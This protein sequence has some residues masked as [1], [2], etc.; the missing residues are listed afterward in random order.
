MI[1]ERIVADNLEALEAKKRSAP[2]ADIQRMALAQPAPLDFAAALRGEAI[3]L[4]AEVKKA[5]PSKGVIRPDFNAVE[6]ART[7]AG[8]GAAAISVLT[9]ARYFQ[10][11]LNYLKVVR[12]RCC[13]VEST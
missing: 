11:S 6:I 4:I 10:G 12:F 2:L 8:N 3:Q 7:Y 1:L 13:S 9:E 5:S